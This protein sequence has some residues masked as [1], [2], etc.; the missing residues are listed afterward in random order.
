MG[1]EIAT[2]D[3]IAY[4]WMANSSKMDA[5]LMGSARDRLNFNETMFIKIFKHFIVRAGCA[6][7]H[8]CAP[9]RYEEMWSFWWDCVD[10][11]PIGKSMT[12]TCCR[13]VMYNRNIRF[14]NGAIPKHASQRLY[15]HD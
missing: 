10:Q 9:E 2:I 11:R 15:V 7:F 14:F 3:R 8:H 13:S 1:N 6:E 12:P 5:N 4:Y